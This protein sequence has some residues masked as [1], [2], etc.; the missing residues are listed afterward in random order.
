[1]PDQ[2][3]DLVQLPGLLAIRGTLQNYPRVEATIVAGQGAQ[4][5]ELQVANGAFFGQ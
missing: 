5:Y 1:M 3:V 4:I 2:V